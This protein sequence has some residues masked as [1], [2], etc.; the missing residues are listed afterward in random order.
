MLNFN[1]YLNKQ[2]FYFGQ[3]PGT[4]YDNVN[5]NDGTTLAANYKTNVTIF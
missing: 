4:D 5:S 1:V 3:D 2:S